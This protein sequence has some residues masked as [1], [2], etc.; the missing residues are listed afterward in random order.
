M[1]PK[2]CLVG[3]VP[4]GKAISVLDQRLESSSPLLRDFDMCRIF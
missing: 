1:F 3:L 2:D 4:L